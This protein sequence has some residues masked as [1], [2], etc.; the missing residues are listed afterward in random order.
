VQGK[1]RS[2]GREIENG[3]I[4]TIVRV[5][6]GVHIKIFSTYRPDGVEADESLAMASCKFPHRDHHAK[7]HYGHPSDEVVI[8]VT[9]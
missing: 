2:F 7:M 5:L 8:L 9:Q 4:K 1:G 6:I 3:T